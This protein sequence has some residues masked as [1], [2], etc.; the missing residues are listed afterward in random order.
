MVPILTDIFSCLPQ[1]LSCPSQNLF[2]PRPLLTQSLQV[3][4]LDSHVP[5]S[6]RTRISHEMLVRFE[7]LVHLQLDP[8]TV[9]RLNPGR[10][11]SVSQ[12]LRG[13]PFQTLGAEKPDA[14]IVRCASRGPQRRKCPKHREISLF[15]Y[16]QT[17][18]V[19]RYPSGLLVRLA[20]QPL[21]LLYRSSPNQKPCLD[22]RFAGTVHWQVDASAYSH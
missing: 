7:H 2:S 19:M 16:Q 8:L 13:C 22:T 21:L 5:F 4:M 15:S 10:I 3:Y 9:F 11:R 6:V 12:A 17:A 14:C 1:S 18:T 20:H